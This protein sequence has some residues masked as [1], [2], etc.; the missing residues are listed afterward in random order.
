MRPGEYE[1][2]SSVGPV[3]ACY[4]A[5]LPVSWIVW[6]RMETPYAWIAAVAVGLCVLSFKVARA[7]FARLAWLNVAIV[8]AFLGAYES[9]LSSRHAPEMAYDKSRG[10]RPGTYFES[11]E[12]LGYGPMPSVR[13]STSRFVDGEPIYDVAHTID[14]RRMRVSPPIPPG[15]P[16]D[17][18]VWFF[19]GSYT[20]GEG[21]E[22]DEAMPYLVGIK[23]GG[24]Y[25]IRNFGFHGYGP[26]QMLAQLRTGESEA[27]AGCAPT[28][29][30]YQGGIFHARRSVGR[31]P[32]GPAA[33]V[34]VFD[35]NGGLELWGKAEDYDFGGPSADML[36][37]LGRSRIYKRHLAQ[38]VDPYA[39]PW[40]AADVEMMFALVEESASIVSRR[41][42]EAEFHVLVWQTNPNWAY[43]QEYV[44]MLERA[45][46][47][48]HKISDAIED[49]QRPRDPRYHLHSHDGHPSVA[50]HEEISDYVVRNI[51]GREV[52]AYGSLPASD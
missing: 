11:N 14:E 20:F 4:V 16:R 1:R 39:R 9:F 36:S 40:S 50:A 47:E 17:G 34:F 29:V 13:V 23:S 7:T 43:S 45:G 6:Q 15:V 42:P 27:R 33:P 3:A 35:E 49:Y 30:V 32:W 46:I 25:E 41:F 51:L 28:H 10:Y 18:C 2:V 22:D 31:V 38:Y 21:V 19:G 48:T 8:V 5:A 52:R 12:V 37:I 26:N 44:A 24:R